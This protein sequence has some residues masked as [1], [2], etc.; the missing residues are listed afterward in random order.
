[1]TSE[2]V[3]EFENFSAPYGRQIKL[4]DV[5]F[6]SDMRLMRITIREGRRFTIMDVDAATADKWGGAMLA[7]AARQKN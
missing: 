2:T 3:E 6:D 4:E 1:M 5:T 7:W